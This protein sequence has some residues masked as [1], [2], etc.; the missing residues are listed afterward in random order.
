MSQLRK[1]LKEKRGWWLWGLWLVSFFLLRLPSLFEP[2]WYGDEGIYLTLGAGIRK[3]VALYQEIHDNKP[4]LLYILAAM[5][6]TVFG[7]RLLLSVW[8][9]TSYAIA[10]KLFLKVFDKRAVAVVLTWLF[11]AVSS[12]PFLEGNIANSEIFMLGP[13]L[14]AVWLL[15]PIEKLKEKQSFWAGIFLGIALILKM[16]ALFS[17][18]ALAFWV[19]SEENLSLKKRISLLFWLGMGVFIPLFLT[20]IWFLLSGGLGA[21]LAAAWGQNIGYLSSWSTGS[22][23]G[24]MGNGV[25]FRAIALVLFW[26]GA[27]IFKKRWGKGLWA[28]MVWLSAEMF[29]AALSGRPY[30]H[31]L[32]GSLLPSF[33]ILGWL[34]VG[35]DSGK[36]KLA[37]LALSLGLWIGVIK[38]FDFYFYPVESY[39]QNFYGWVGGKKSREEY[40]KYFGGQILENDRIVEIIKEET[41]EEERIFVWADRPYLY[42][43]SG[44][45]P[46][47]RFTVA[48]HVVDFG[49]EE[50]LLRALREEWPKLV[51]WEEKENRKFE[52]LKKLIDNYYS[53]IYGA[54]KITI[55]KLN[56]GEV[57]II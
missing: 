29:G 4:P 39:Y 57:G 17:L 31:Y 16:P 6:K 7:F 44:R 19:A 46:A 1:K 30:P 55:Y 10:Y 2:Y 34:W 51:V 15:W 49:G 3:G 52:E 45:L 5:G 9:L 38:A 12:V 43:E 36:E 35:K 23:G 50:E 14:A 37:I 27:W 32:I 25:K 41:E 47:S 54:G 40:R 42:A 28:G 22:H 8:M 13:S 18:A 20:I 33:W 48:Y 53:P 11:L 21:Y 24:G 26:V 56:E